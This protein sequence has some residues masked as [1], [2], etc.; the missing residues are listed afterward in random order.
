VQLD[1]DKATLTKKSTVQHATRGSSGI[2]VISSKD[3]VPQPNSSSSSNGTAGGS[4]FGFSKPAGAAPAA[5]AASMA[6]K[7]RVAEVVERNRALPDV[8]RQQVAT[9]LRTQGNDHYR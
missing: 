3:T 2:Q 7:E 9:S 5:P 6:H 8:D 1:Q 4:R